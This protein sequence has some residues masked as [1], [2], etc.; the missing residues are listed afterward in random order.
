MEAPAAALCSATWDAHVG[1]L[2]APGHGRPEGGVA[3]PCGSPKLRRRRVDAAAA[4]GR[5]VG[6][7]RAWAASRDA[8]RGEDLQ[9]AAAKP[10]ADSDSR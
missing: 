7:Y 2:D 9:G 6:D 10:V 8:I 4:T 3:A 5:G 1:A